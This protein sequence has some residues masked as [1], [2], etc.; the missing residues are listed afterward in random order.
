MNFYDPEPRLKVYIPF[1]QRPGHCIDGF[2]RVKINFEDHNKKISK[3][4]MNFI[5]AWG[6]HGPGRPPPRVHRL[7]GPGEVGPPGPPSNYRPAAVRMG[8]FAGHK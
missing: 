3:Q 8:T 1:F 5:F 4:K 6:V 7:A 2:G